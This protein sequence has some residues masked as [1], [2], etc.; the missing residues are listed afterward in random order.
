MASAAPNDDLPQPVPLPPGRALNASGP[1]ELEPEV[2]PSWPSD[3]P[4]DAE[5]QAP[6]T[7]ECYAAVIDANYHDM[8]TKNQRG[9]AGT[10]LPDDARH[11]FEGTPY[12]EASLLYYRNRLRLHTQDVPGAHVPED[13]AVFTWSKKGL[14][15]RHTFPIEFHHGLPDG[16]ANDRWITSFITEPGHNSIAIT[17]LPD[18]PSADPQDPPIKRYEVKI[19][20][21]PCTPDRSVR[22]IPPN[23]AVVLPDRRMPSTDE[24]LANPNL[25][26]R[27]ADPAAEPPAASRKRPR[28]ADAAAAAPSES[29]AGSQEPAEAPPAKRSRVDFTR[30]ARYTTG[31]GVS[32]QAQRMQARVAFATAA[33][34]V[35]FASVAGDVAGSDDRDLQHASANDQFLASALH[36]HMRTVREA[37]DAA[38]REANATN[39]SGGG[40]NGKKVSP[41]AVLAAKLDTT[42]AQGYPTFLRVLLDAALQ[43]LRETDRANKKLT[44]GKIAMQKHFSRTF[45]F[46]G[47]LLDSLAPSKKD[48]SQFKVVAKGGTDR[49]TYFTVP[50]DGAET[51]ALSG[52]RLTPGSKVLHV[53]LRPRSGTGW[54]KTCAAA[55]GTKK[56]PVQS[57]YIDPKSRPVLHM[58]YEAV[59]GVVPSVPGG[60]DL[61]NANAECI[62]LFGSKKAP[63]VTVAN[64]YANLCKLLDRPLDVNAAP[65]AMEE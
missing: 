39:G 19:D 29:T 45:A 38:Q 27:T 6:S 52:K 62:R 35:A 4:A 56:V 43:A 22:R 33:R 53:R 3:T 9:S 18:R 49:A 54:H 21:T 2:E 17:P 11:K 10:A 32:G 41:K 37:K 40:K 50:E 61:K 58:L 14:T 8:I 34:E 25:S 7:Y 15:W 1:R 65:D 42:F 46:L 24:I 59:F 13:G 31:G 23:P 5:T 60:D 20:Y 47:H 16:G 48:R 28:P 30:L 57:F 64:L 63:G 12:Y 26:H 51:C 44:K 36:L 55:E